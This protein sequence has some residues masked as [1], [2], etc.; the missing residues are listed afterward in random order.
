MK[1]CI[2]SIVNFL[3][4]ICHQHGYE[5]LFEPTSS[6]S[7]T[8]L[9]LNSIDCLH[10]LDIK[11]LSAVIRRLPVT[12][13]NY[14]TIGQWQTKYRKLTTKTPPSMVQRNAAIDPTFSKKSDKKNQRKR[15]NHL[16]IR[17]KGKSSKS[18]I[19]WESL[20][21]ATAEPAKHNEELMK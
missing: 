11:L 5:D 20:N 1:I 17:S 7:S 16:E 3:P 15:R 10:Q 21:S 2:L 14:L 8:A 12:K 18:G 13:E 19:I 6:G 9:T 4:S